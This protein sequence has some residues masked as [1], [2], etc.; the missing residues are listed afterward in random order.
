MKFRFLLTAL[1][2][3]PLATSLL[4][5]E[6]LKLPPKEKFHLFLLVGQSNMAG[7]GTVEEHATFFDSIARECPH[8]DF[9]WLGDGF[10]A[11]GENSRGG[12]ILA[13]GLPNLYAVAG[14]QNIW[15]SLPALGAY[16]ICG[17]D[18]ETTLPL[19]AAALGKP[20]IGF[21]TAGATE[22]LGRYGILCCGSANP[23][24]VCDIVKKIAAEQPSAFM[25]DAGWLRRQLDIEGCVDTILQIM[26]GV[27]LMEPIENRAA[28]AVVNP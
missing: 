11:D 18:R 25:P 8:I 6:P 7:R 3:V 14:R 13:A 23:T 21:S 2:L 17:R 22:L 5:S 16:V 19:A 12:D 20:V 26:A 28:G 10:G 4:A 15:P 24:V 1:L 27:R 9:A